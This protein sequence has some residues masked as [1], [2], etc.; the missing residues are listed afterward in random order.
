MNA[1]ANAAAKR[2]TKTENAK[3]NG[4]GAVNGKTA[5]AKIRREEFCDP[6]LTKQAARVTIIRK[7]HDME[8]RINRR[9]GDR[10]SVIGMGASSLHEASEKEGAKTIEFAYEHGINYFDLA[11]SESSCFL[12]YGKA[13]KGVRDNVFFQLHFGANYEDGE[14]GW[15][16]DAK[17][18]SRSVGSQ[19]KALG[20][21]HIDYGFIHC[22]DEPEDWKKYRDGGALDLLLDYKKQ[23][24]VRHIGLSSHSPA[25]VRELLGTGLPDIIM[26]S[27]NPAYDYREGDFAIGGTDERAETYRMC[28]AAGVGITVM[29][30]FSGGQLLDARTSPFG[31]AL[32]EYQCIKYALDK[33]GVV[34]VLPGARNTT[35]L[36]R[37]L[38][39]FDA[40]D[41]EKD[42]SVIGTF[43]PADAAGKCVYCNHCKPCPAG[44]DIGMINKYYDLARIGDALAANHYEKL[45]R[46]A[47]DC[48][49]CGHCDRRCPFGVGQSARM[50]EIAAYF[51]K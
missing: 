44:L 46:H 1:A 24:V 25:I 9:T 23:G 19:L 11:A 13:L 47:S 33:P 27:I 50:R 8:Y 4:A 30:A 22:I 49:N 14:Y 38:G 6:L 12:Y 32:T 41:E 16:T 3:K 5:G 31:K 7:E 26:F 37:I 39:Y 18:I 51:G 21:D 42:W 34:T 28:E 20:T 36:K 17:T 48:I 2:R 43:A 40:T 45:V 29:K 15:T 10:I 35:D